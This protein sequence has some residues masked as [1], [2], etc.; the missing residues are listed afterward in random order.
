MNPSAGHVRSLI[1]AGHLPAILRGEEAVWRTPAEINGDMLPTDH[2][3]LLKHGVHPLVARTGA[4][5]VGNMLEDALLRIA[6]DALGVF[7]A[8]QCFYVEVLAEDASES[9]LRVD[10]A[11]L[12]C[13]LWQAFLAHEDALRRLTLDNRPTADACF[14]VTVAGFRI[15]QRDHGVTGFGELPVL[16]FTSR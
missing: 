13:G 14:L 6:S 4:T 16:P 12:A 11:R 1:K 15:L 5:E 7:C 8:V 2:V 10:R 3:Q 9:P